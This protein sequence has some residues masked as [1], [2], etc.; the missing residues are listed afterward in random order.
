VKRGKALSRIN[1]LRVSAGHL[2]RVGPFVCLGPTI[3]T[4]LTT[5]QTSTFKP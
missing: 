5:E 2:I 1:Y 3:K 4:L